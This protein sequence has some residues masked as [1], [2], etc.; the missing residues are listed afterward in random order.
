MNAL[1]NRYW[2]ECA[3]S[4]SKLNLFR[5]VF[6]TV[7][8]VDC[9]LDVSHAPRYGAG[10]FNVSHLPWLDPILPLPTRAGFLIGCVLG[11]Y[12]ALQVA[13]GVATAVSVRLLTVLF[14][15][16]YFI[17]QLD[18]YQHHYLVFLL[19]VVSC[20]VPWDDA[21]RRRDAGDTT[22]RHWAIRLLVVQ[23]AIVYLWAA[24][25]KM[26]PQWIDGTALQ[27]QVGEAWAS[28]LIDATFGF[29]GTARLV[30]LTE[31]VLCGMLLFRPLWPFAVL[32]GI[33]FH[34]GIE[35]TGFRI[36]L[37][38]Y[39]MIA[40]YFL[41]LPDSWMEWL[42]RAWRQVIS[43]RIA[44]LTARA[45]SAAVCFGVAVLLAAGGAGLVAAIPLDTRAGLALFA[46]AVTMV[47][48]L[49]AAR[50]DARAAL[51]GAGTAAVAAGALL[52][53]LHRTT[54]TVPDYYRL[55]GGSARRLGDLEQSEWA[56]GRLVALRPRS[57]HAHLKLAQVRKQRGD[58]DGARVQANRAVELDPGD[59]DAVKLLRELGGEP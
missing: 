3:V 49:L 44:R 47:A 18:S 50:R 2:F 58:L 1:W 31:L 38:S 41:L 12:L 20:M 53:A 16:R 25:S 11:S 6:F 36:G 22:I 43:A 30:L 24:I 45:P 34:A 7:L 5:L 4:R 8:A 32:I 13:F 35:I 14:G 46:F 54:E 52:L 9:F 48:C 57:A 33:P 23:V 51:L 29:A 55:L 40:F 37:F 56:Y 42:G 28:D 10:D 26:T 39:F 15:Y 21:R 17:S 59:A 27:R 19:L